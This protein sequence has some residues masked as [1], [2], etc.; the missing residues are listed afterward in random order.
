MKPKYSIGDKV[1]VVRN[2]FF[3]TKRNDYTDLEFLIQHHVINGISLPSENSISIPKR[4]FLYR[5]GFDDW[6][7]EDTLFDTSEEARE[8]LSKHL[9]ALVKKTRCMKFFSEEVDQY[10]EEEL[11]R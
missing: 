10:S 2:N 3:T 8:A 5:L 6:I 4:T 11:L 7:R 1:F 9:T